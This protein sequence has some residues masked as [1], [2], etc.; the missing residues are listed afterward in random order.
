[1]D[2]ATQ[3]RYSVRIL[4]QALAV[5]LDG[6]GTKDA[7]IG[8]YAADETALREGIERGYRTLARDATALPERIELVNRANAVRAW[9][10]T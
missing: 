7:T 1:M 9:S 3:V 10:L 5:V 6:G 2:P 4:E 8:S